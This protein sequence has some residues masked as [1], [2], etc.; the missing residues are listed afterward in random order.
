MRGLKA[1]RVSAAVWHRDDNG[2]AV[3]E[4][5]ESEKENKITL[6]K[7]KCNMILFA[8]FASASAGC[9]L[10]VLMM[11]LVSAQRL[12]LSPN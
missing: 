11:S 7:E 9:F 6:Y 1:C 12:A 2:Q 10:I 4:D 5:K 8:I 3:Q